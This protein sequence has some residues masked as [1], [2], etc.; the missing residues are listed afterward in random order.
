MNK[1]ENQEKQNWVVAYTTQ[2]IYKMRIIRAILEKE[3]IPH[4][5]INKK[6]TVSVMDGEVELYVLEEDRNKV[7]KIIED[8]SFEEADQ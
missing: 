2:K 1:M 8:T 4:Q 7:K 6:E 5:T 3:G